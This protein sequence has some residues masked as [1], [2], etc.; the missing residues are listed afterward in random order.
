MKK[1][2]NM[3]MAILVFALTIFVFNG[4][5]ILLSYVSVFFGVLL[6][7]ESGVSDTY[8]YLLGHQNLYSFL[9]YF[10]AFVLFAL[11]YY[12][13]V[14]QP[15]GLKPFLKARTE[16]LSPACFGWILLLAFAV[17]HLT[18]LVFTLIDMFSPA[19]V[20]N[21]SQ[22]VET[23]GLTE[24]SF[25]WFLSTLILPPLTEEIIFRGLLL[26]YLK[27]TGIPFLAANLIQAVC[28][29]I[30]HQNLAQGIYTALLGFLL[31]YL[32]QRYVTLIAPM[33]L[34]F[35]YN[36]FGTVLVDLENAFLPAAGQGLLVLQ[37]IPLAVLA[38][39]M[40]Q[41]RIGEKKKE[42]TA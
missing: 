30:Y 28:F 5:S 11:W 9:I 27:K 37:S 21:Y 20:E 12:F 13:A 6:R 26:G 7:G 4:T 41:L 40:I 19:A 1:T 23:S 24:Y 35:L 17:Q 8:Y 14:I 32:A 18:S 2:S 25:V 22:M 16:G 39:V 34:H 10:T 38:I 3:L 29:G 42:E 31:G 33:F 15:R 36:L